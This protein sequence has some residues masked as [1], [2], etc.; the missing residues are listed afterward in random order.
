MR[1]TI[2]IPLFFALVTVAST[3]VADDVVHLKS[4]G[5]VRGTVTLQDPTEGVVVLLA[6]GTI[7]KIPAADVARVDYGDA[8]APPVATP[9]PADPAPAP[10]PPAPPP[11]AAPPPPPA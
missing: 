3:A 6:D 11:A 8:G 5:R 9:A 7:K 1:R 2:A 4:G 10:A